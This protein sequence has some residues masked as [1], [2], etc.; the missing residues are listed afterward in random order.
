MRIPSRIRIGSALWRVVVHERL[1]LEGVEC[2]GVTR[3]AQELIELGLTR[4]GLRVTENCV[5][6]TLLHEVL[7]S[8]SLTYGLGLGERQIS[9][10]AGALLAVFR[11]NKLLDFA[12]RTP[13]AGGG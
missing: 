13:V 11:S 2:L 9:G 10:L 7:H 6:D 4:E 3:Q 12:D 1:E 5:A 8:V